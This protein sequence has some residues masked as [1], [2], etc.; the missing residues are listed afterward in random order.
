MITLLLAAWLQDPSA[1]PET[2]D[3]A[4]EAELAEHMEEMQDWLAETA[5]TLESVA[6]DFD[7]A[8]DEDPAGLAAAWSRA[9][10]V[11]ARELSW[12][13]VEDPIDMAARLALEFDALRQQIDAAPDGIGASYSIGYDFNTDG[14]THTGPDGEPI[15][16]PEP[17]ADT[18][19]SDDE[20]EQ[21]F[22]PDGEMTS[23]ERDTPRGPVRWRTCHEWDDEDGYVFIGGIQFLAGDEDNGSLA[24]VA[25]AVASD[26]A[27]IRDA[28]AEPAERIVE[29]MGNALS[30]APED[31]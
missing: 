23:G 2:T 15:D 7:A 14:Q 18:G 21:P 31:E 8:S 25:I 3:P 30:V 19:S 5:G 27:A 4:A 11:H 24:M 12:Y 13:R 26:D 28:M 16:P 29:I 6:A 20:P 1:L 10:T 22:C 17:D 9:L